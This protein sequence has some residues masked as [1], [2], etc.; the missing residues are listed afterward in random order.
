MTA[1]I[2]TV[3]T[4]I[5]LGNIS[6]S[7]A[8]FLSV[9]LAKLGVAV[10]R[11]TSV[12]DNEK[13]LKAALENGFANADVV[14]TTG[15]LGPTSDDITKAVAAN[16]FGL[17][18]EEHQPTMERIRQRFAGKYPNGDHPGAVCGYLRPRTIRS[19]LKPFYV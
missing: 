7:N 13:R 4:E 17:K 5:L 16:F 10:F 3:G 11:H 15:G 18:M 19:F 2:L 9:E 6:N 14:I 8:A 12:G 1:E